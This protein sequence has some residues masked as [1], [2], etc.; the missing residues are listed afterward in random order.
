M[1]KVIWL[2]AALG[3]AGLFC[4]L[5][6]WQLDR[7]AGKRAASEDFERK[8]AAPQV[9]LNTGAVGPAAA[10]HRATAD[11]HFLEQTILLDNQLHGGRAGYLVY[12]TFALDG[13]HER[14]L[15]NRGWIDAGPDRG[16]IPQLRS[17]TVDQ[18]LSG[19]LSGPPQVGLRLQGDD[20]IEPLASATW[21]VQA[22][23]F[24]R[25]TQTLGAELLPITLLLDPDPQSGLQ[26]EWAAPGSGEQRHLGYAFQWFALAA[27]VVIVAA[28]IVLR[29]RQPT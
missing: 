12:S 13:R 20:W 3:A 17:H 10:G 21:R 23:D 27:A 26:R 9:D 8:Q 16:R 11:G 18:R 7:A 28:V 24:D 14:V 4:G 29:A 6:L 5:G 2:A 1:A 15:M 25:L 19:R 22:I